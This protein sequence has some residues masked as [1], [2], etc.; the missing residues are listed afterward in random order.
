MVV[1]TNRQHKTGILAMPEP[2]LQEW[3]AKIVER[4]PEIEQVYLLGGKARGPQGQKPDFSFLLYAGYD[5]ALD[6]LRSLAREEG[7]LRNVDAIVHLYVENYG[8]TFCGLWGGGLIPNELLQDWEEGRDYR[9]WLERS[10]RARPL[11][12]RL[13]LPLE[14]RT[15]DRRREASGSELHDTAS[16]NLEERDSSQPSER[17]DNDRR[18]DPMEL[19]SQIDQA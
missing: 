7:E 14:R 1:M 15:A 17:R 3:L 6:L 11:S 10:D 4:H 18:R 19:V 16:L 13:R 9:L 2:W 8:A 5:N 12:E